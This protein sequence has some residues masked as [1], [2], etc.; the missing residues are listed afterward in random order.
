MLISEQ[1]TSTAQ[2][3]LNFVSHQQDIVCLA[4][5]ADAGEVTG[6]CHDD[7]AF[8]LNGLDQKS[9]GIRRNGPGERFAVTIGHEHESRGQGSKM[10]AILWL[11]GSGNHRCCAAMK[12]AV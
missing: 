6:W 4:D 7:A 2:T 11:C 1:P 8:A 9:G 5:F 3:G 10:L 12:I